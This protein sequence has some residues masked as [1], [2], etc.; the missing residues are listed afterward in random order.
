MLFFL[1]WLLNLMGSDEASY[2]DT[3]MLDFFEVKFEW[4]VAPIL[5]RNSE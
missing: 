2:I 5:G 4:R 1:Y 3:Y